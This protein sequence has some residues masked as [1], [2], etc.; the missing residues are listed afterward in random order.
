MAQN[1][2]IFYPCQQ[3]AFRKPGTAVNTSKEV[4]G[5]QSISIATTFNLEQAFELGQLAIYENI[6]GI[7][8]VDITL[9]K[10]LAF[11]EIFFPFS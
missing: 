9:N 6:E 4:H 3:V 7:P 5:V 1:T 10:V 11:S 8:T 2:R